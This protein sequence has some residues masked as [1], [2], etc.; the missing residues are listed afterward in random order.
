MGCVV[1]TLVLQIC[2]IKG[3]AVRG[4][5]SLFNRSSQD[6]ASVDRW[7]TLQLDCCGAAEAGEYFIGAFD[8]VGRL[9]ICYCS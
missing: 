4:E 3:A 1:S 7:F 6:E 2:R 9:I 5:S 8:S